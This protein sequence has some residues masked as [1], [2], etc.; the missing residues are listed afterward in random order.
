M[1]PKF[2]LGIEEEYQTIDAET[3]ELRSHIHTEI[4][5]K[6]KARMKEVMTLA[7]EP[8]SRGHMRVSNP[9]DMRAQ[10]EAARVA[11]AAGRNGATVPPASSGR[12][13]RSRRA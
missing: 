1:K 2:T 12:G 13:S 4:L 10:L 6:G 5:S 9:E 8:G 7:A 3:R 11:V